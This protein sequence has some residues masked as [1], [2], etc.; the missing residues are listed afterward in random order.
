MTAT[1]YTAHAIR[2]GRWWE[3]SVD[4]ILDGRVC[5]QAKQL[6]QVEWEA[7]TIVAMALDVPLSH[8]DVTVVVDDM[9]SAH[10]V[11]ERA[12][13]IRTLRGRIEKLGTEWPKRLVR[14][15]RTFGAS[16]CP[17]PRWRPSSTSHVSASLS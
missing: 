5:G 2:E 10:D 3:I 8:V 9:G 14:W 7:R 11:Q 17:T 13:H 12:E 1:T 16:H 4:G 6:G 15:Y